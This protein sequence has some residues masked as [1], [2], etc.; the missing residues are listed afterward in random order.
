MLQTSYEIKTALVTSLLPT[1]SNVY[2][3]DYKF[4]P[5]H[6]KSVDDAPTVTI[7]TDGIRI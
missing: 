2:G 4:V 7:K 3:K 5:I 6:I 1:F